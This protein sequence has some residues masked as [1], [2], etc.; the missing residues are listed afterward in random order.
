MKSLPFFIAY[1]YLFKTAY[2]QNIGTMVI[3]S[4]L[5]IFIGTVALTLVAAITKGFETEI[6]KKIQG[7]HAQ[8]IIRGNSKDLEYS[9][10]STILKN[11]FPEVSWVSPS[12][13]KHGIIRPANKQSKTTDEHSSVVLIR[14][15][16]P[17][18]DEKV[19]VFYKKII[20]SKKEKKKKHLFDFLKDD[21]ILI[22]SGLA[23]MLGLSIG[24]EIELLI[25]ED[26]QK[27]SKKVSFTAQ[28]AIISGIFKTGIDDAD[29]GMIVCS[30][31]FL[32]DI[33]GETPIDQ[34]NLKL[35]AS[36]SEEEVINRLINRTNL[37]VYAW[38]DL[39]PALVS[40]LT[41]EKYVSFAIL[42]LVALVASMN[43]ISLIFMFITQKRSDIAIL[44]ACGASTST[45]SFIFLTVGM[46]IT[47]TATLLGLGVSFFISQ[48]LKTHPFIKLPDAYLVTHLP[49]DLTPSIIIAVFCLVCI[50]GF[51]AA[52]FPVRKIKALNIAEVLRFEA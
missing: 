21:Q 27:N 9:A 38:R 8:I 23:E 17:D 31:S 10:L 22:G 25:P 5:G 39:Y 11:E 2:E 34:V 7:V 40:A 37:D 36:A 24:D 3:I 15:I 12:S 32:E 29:T 4:F 16:D 13:T 44:K 14:A 47:T 26:A 1:R 18:L 35:I 48:F 41:L 45:V 20:T 50:L 46:F 6:H 49:V 33:F 51:V 52:C 43:M 19:T 42:A 28:K 30:F